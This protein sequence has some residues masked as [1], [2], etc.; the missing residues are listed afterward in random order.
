[1]AGVEIVALAEKFA[2]AESIE[3]AV[4]DVEKPGAE[5]EQQRGEY[6]HVEAHGAG[7]EPSPERSDGW[8]IQAKQVP[9]M[10]KVV[11]APGQGLVYDGS[12]PRSMLGVCYEAAGWGCLRAALRR[13][14]LAGTTATSISGRVAGSGML[15]MLSRPSATR[16][17]KSWAL[18]R[19]PSGARTRT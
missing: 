8:R 15:S 11:E 3:D 19:L 1:M 7:E 10:R 16:I 12:I 6:W 14:G 13:W 18:K 17:K 5:G 4:G 9:P 2:F